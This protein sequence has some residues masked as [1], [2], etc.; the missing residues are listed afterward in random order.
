MTNK[1]WAQS[2]IRRLGGDPTNENIVRAVTIWMRFEGGQVTNPLFQT[3]P[4]GNCGSRTVKTSA[5]NRTF[6]VYCTG[7]DSAAAAARLLTADFAKE[8]GYGYDKIVA[9][10][11]ASD[12]M[13][14]FQAVWDSRWEETHYGGA[15]STARRNMIAAYN[16]G[17]P[18][19][20]QLRG[21]T[22]STVR[23]TD[24]GG[25]ARG[26]SWTPTP[27]VGTTLADVL[28]R[29]VSLTNPTVIWEVAQEVAK[30]I[31]WGERPEDVYLYLVD[32]VGKKASD[33]P[34]QI[35]NEDR[36]FQ[37]TDRA[38]DAAGPAR[39]ALDSITSV[40]QFLSGVWDFVTDDE[41]VRYLLALVIG[42]PL[43]W[44]AFNRLNS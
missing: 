18:Y 27:K 12:P 37:D 5:G 1:E 14:F 38:P 29:D 43:T 42:V 19:E 23:N 13:A 31:P 17:L 44:H 16:S 25:R 11:Q 35:K 24:S 7:E 41:N 9:A 32:F 2:L 4:P 10:I 30:L 33:V 21:G 20:A 3:W 22:G 36:T 15:N 8:R 28:G 39:D 40:P 6:P 26:G 34:F